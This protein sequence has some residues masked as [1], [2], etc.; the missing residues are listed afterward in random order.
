MPSGAISWI[1]TTWLVGGQQGPVEFVGR[2][3]PQGVGDVA[4]PRCS[5][6]VDTVQQRSVQNGVQAPRRQRS[7]RRARRSADTAADERRYPRSEGRQR[8]SPFRRKA[9]RQTSAQS[10]SAALWIPLRTPLSIGIQPNIELKTI[11]SGFSATR[12]YAGAPMLK[13]SNCGA[14]VEVR[15]RT[16]DRR[17]GAPLSVGATLG[18]GT[19]T[20]VGVNGKFFPFHQWR[21]VPDLFARG[22]PRHLVD[23]AGMLASMPS[24]GWWSRWFCGAMCWIA[25]ASGSC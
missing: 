21:C 1:A 4:H 10:D 15:P 7:A 3:G 2:L 20:S 24:C 23:E 12:F 6:I 8:T 11:L 22:S 9:R 5:G 19:A 16:S 17:T 14:T 18:D 13:D 25:L